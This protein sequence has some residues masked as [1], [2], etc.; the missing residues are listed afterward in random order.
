MKYYE[1]CQ[2]CKGECYVGDKD[3]SGDFQFRFLSQLNSL[4][5]TG[6]VVACSGCAKRS[7]WTKQ[8]VDVIVKCPLCETVFKVLAL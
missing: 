7:P 6:F 5:D 1:K 4:C 3:C 2:G 8:K